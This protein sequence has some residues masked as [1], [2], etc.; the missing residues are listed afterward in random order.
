[1]L[2]HRW[3]EPDDLYWD[4]EFEDIETGMEN[5]YS[6]INVRKTVAMGFYTAGAADTPDMDEEPFD[7]WEDEWES[8]PRTWF[9]FFLDL[10]AW[11][12]GWQ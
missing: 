5:V 2:S 1:M 9:Q 3:F 7:D 12:K 11:W 10:L 8:E 6:D 4:S